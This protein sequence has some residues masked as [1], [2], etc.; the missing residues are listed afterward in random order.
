MIG[1]LIYSISL[2]GLGFCAGTYYFHEQYG[3]LEKELR[4]KYDPDYA[5]NYIW[6][7]AV[8]KFEKCDDERELSWFE[9]EYEA[10]ES[11]WQRM[12]S[13][14]DHTD[15]PSD[16]EAD[17]IRFEYI[18]WVK[19]FLAHTKERDLPYKKEKIK[20]LELRLASLEA[21]EKHLR[22]H[23]N[24]KAYDEYVKY[25]DEFRNMIKDNPDII[26]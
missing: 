16:M 26:K 10:L 18:P 24:Q 19:E 2:L 21:I 5:G 7:S 22:D 6:T 3:D 4:E 12:V 8:E 9:G 13:K 15:F 17:I 11:S 25:D 1:K 20:I 14:I 23:S